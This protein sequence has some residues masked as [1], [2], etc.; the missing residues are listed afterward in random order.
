MQGVS[1]RKVK[2]VTEELV[3]HAFSASAISP[4]QQAAGCV[5]EAFCER[6]LNEP[7]PYLIL[8]ARSA[9]VQDDGI[10]ASQPVLI[11]I[12]VDWEG[13]RQ[14]SRSSWPTGRAG[15]AGRSFWR[16]C[17][18]AACTAWSSWSPR[19][20]GL[21]KAIA[22]GLAGACWQRCYVRAPQAHESQTNMLERLNEEIRRRTYVVRIF[23]NAES[24]LRL[25]RALTAERHEAWLEGHRYLNMDLLRS[26]R[27]KRYARRPDN[28]Q[29]HQGDARHPSPPPSLASATLLD[30]RA[31][32]PR[33]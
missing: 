26:A 29:A 3:G 14:G 31:T 28:A 24:C 9:R 13:R 27:R 33:G 19:S 30:K 11:A 21:K 8:D 2:Q 25:V 22:E 32:A 5:A 12:G 10:I 17:G 4:T 6:K 1:T 18:P 15:R 16:R 23:P 7:F 20:P